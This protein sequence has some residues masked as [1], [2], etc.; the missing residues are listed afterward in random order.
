MFFNK[1][2]GRLG[3]YLRKK[4][5]CFVKHVV[6]NKKSKNMSNAIKKSLMSMIAVI[7]TI[8]SLFGFGSFAFAG[9]DDDDDDDK[10]GYTK[11]NGNASVQSVKRTDGTAALLLR[12]SGV[13]KSKTKIKVRVINTATGERFTQKFKVRLDKPSGTKE[14][15]VTDLAPGVKY[16]FNVKLKRKR[17]S[18][19]DDDD[20]KDRERRAAEAA[21]AA[22]AAAGT[23]T[24]PATTGTTGTET[25]GGTGTGT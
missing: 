19:N 24:A 2:V 1:S 21:A 20:K 18:D 13:K 7:F 17:S 6:I 22:A 5:Y 14:V 9:H 15:V 25:G 11:K 8:V 16:D 3:R 10:K 4:L 12:Y 23:T